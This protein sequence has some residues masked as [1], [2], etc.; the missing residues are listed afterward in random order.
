VERIVKMWGSEASWMQAPGVA[1][2]ALHEASMLSLDCSKARTRLGWKPRLSLI[3]S[4]EWI[5]EW[6]KAHADGENLVQV[7]LR[8]IEK[9]NELQ[10]SR[11]E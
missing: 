4:L 9:F 11:Q 7:T 5:V 8:Q 6:Y 1:G 2:G 10:R 3:E